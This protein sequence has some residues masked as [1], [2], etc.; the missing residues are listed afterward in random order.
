M[1]ATGLKFE[2]HLALHFEEDD[3]GNVSQWQMVWILQHAML[4]S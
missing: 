2:P 1:V 4:L 3:L